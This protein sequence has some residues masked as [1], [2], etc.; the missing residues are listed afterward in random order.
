V[1]TEGARGGKLR[2]IK[3]VATLPQAG[4]ADTWVA[5][6]APFFLAAVAG[7]GSKSVC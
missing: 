2:F 3:E 7:S 1:Y 6:A 4:G 5:P